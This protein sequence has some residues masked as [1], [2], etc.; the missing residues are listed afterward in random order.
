[1][2]KDPVNSEIDEDK[3][4]GPTHEELKVIIGLSVGLGS[5]VIIAVILAVVYKYRKRSA[6]YDDP[7]PN[8]AAG[9]PEQIKK[10]S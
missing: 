4:C 7:S 6:K 9:T 8:K 10:K 3:C 2:W 1:V 5:L